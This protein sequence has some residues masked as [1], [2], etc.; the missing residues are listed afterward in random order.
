L[1]N[2]GT[3]EDL[4]RLFKEMLAHLSISHMAIGGGDLPPESSPGVGVLGADFAVDRGRYRIERIYRG[5][6]S[7]PLNPGVTSPLAQPVSASRKAMRC[8]RWTGET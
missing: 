5:D 4:N 3:R 1:P 7:D 6:P 2:V 8:S